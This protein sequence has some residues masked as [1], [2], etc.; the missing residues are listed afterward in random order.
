MSQG[1]T[2][3]LAQLNLTCQTLRQTADIDLHCH[4]LKAFLNTNFHSSIACKVSEI[5]EKTNLEDDLLPQVP[6]QLISLLSTLSDKGYVLLLQNHTDVN[7]SWVILQPE[8]LLTEVN[9][10]IFAP[11]N[12]KEHCSGF[13]MSTGVVPLSKII[14]KFGEPNNHVII[15]Y[16]THLEFCF[17]N[18]DKHT[19]EMITKDETLQLTPH[20]HDRVEEYYFFP[21]LVQ[22]KR[23]SDVCQPQETIK[24]ECGWFY[25]CNEPTEQ[26]TTRFLHVLILCLAFSC[27]SPD[28]PTERE[29]VVLL[30]SCSVWKHG[31]AWW[32]NDG[33]ETIVEVGLQCCWVAVMLHCPDT[34]KVQC[35][36]LRTKVINTVLKTKQDFCPAIGM[37]EFLIA[38]SCLQYPFEGKN[39][40]LYNMREIARVVMK[41]DE[42]P[43]NTKGKSTIHISQLL[44]FEPFGGVD[45]LIDSFFAPDQREL[46][47]T[48]P[49]FIKMAIIC[50]KELDDFKKSS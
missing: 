6:S 1:L 30:R 20:G 23:P 9:G 24:Y 5:A 36:E 38:P 47:L 15:R 37:K 39:L 49:N 25:T 11:D 18:K 34:R 21:V 10:S 46:S 8:V 27:D 22:K 43:K 31:I 26:L 4:I 35:A 45:N 7:K 13:A 41:G 19:L 33:I 16:L 3:L 2:A 42:Y 28:E 29:S 44:P 50:H 48:K 40:I 17:R 32:T 12:F 14:E